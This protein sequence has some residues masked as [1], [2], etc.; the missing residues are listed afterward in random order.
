MRRRQFITPLGGAAALCFILSPLGYPPRAEGCAS[1][2]SPYAGAI[3]D[4]NVQAWN[5]SIQGLISNAAK[6][7]V[8][9]IA[10]F[11]NS[12]AGG[13]ATVDA[14]LAAKQTSP[15]LIV[16]GAPKIGF[17]FGNDLPT[18]YLSST[19]ADVKNGTYGLIGEILYT[20]GDKPDHPPT[21]RG[22]VTVDPLAPGTTLLL[23]GLRGKT[24]PLL[25]HWEAWA[26]ERDWPR[27]DKLY[28]NWP[29]QR[30]V[31]PSLAYA[32]PDQADTILSS[33]RNVWGIISRLVDGRYRFV[34][35]AKQA[36]LGKPM[37]DKCGF[38][39]PEW[40]AVLL[41][42]S[43]RLMYGSDEYSNAGRAWDEYPRIIAR[44]RQ[45]AGQLPTAVAQTI[46]WDNAATLYGSK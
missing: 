29:Q 33:H 35:P 32:S 34:D 43:D 30:F 2:P 5:P 15:D 17:I 20:H 16:A 28:A 19:L 11:A 14:V 39:L 4:A 37:F 22:E 40:R 36:M 38:L 46:S 1:L 44:Y 45:I 21:P 6:A 24:V 3:F 13:S 8:E 41:K 12:R 42:H 26:W 27:F 25:T 18:R 31:L 9:R 23:N 7:G 10:L